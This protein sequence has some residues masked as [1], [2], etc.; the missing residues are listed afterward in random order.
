MEKTANFN[1]NK[2]E[3]T[4]PMRLADFNQN[5][6]IIDAALANLNTAVGSKAEQSAVTALTTAVPK[7]AVGTYTGDTT[8]TG[9]A[10]DVGFAPKMVFIWA[11][12]CDDSSTYN[13]KYCGMVVEGQS[14]QDILKLTDTGFRVIST[15]DNNGYQE[16]PYLNSTRTYFYFAVG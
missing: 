5:S 6:D 10:V 7:I 4:D 3:V 2:P 9:M 15:K 11:N 14:L 1:L 13:T 16:F 8:I 12:W